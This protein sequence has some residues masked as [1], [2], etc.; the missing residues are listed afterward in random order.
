M[1]K[2]TPSILVTDISKSYVSLSARVRIRALENF[3]FSCFPGTVTLLVGANG[4]GKST[5]LRI[6]SGLISPSH[7]SIQLNT[8][9]NKKVKSRDIGYL[10]ENLNF[11]KGISSIRFLSYL[12]KLK[13]LK[14]PT[15]HAYDWLHTFGITN[16]WINLPMDLYSEGMKRR[17]GLAIA[18]MGNPEIIL[19]DEPLENLDESIRAKSLDLFNKL[20]HED[21]R[22]IVIATHNQNIFEQ[23]ADQILHL[24]AGKI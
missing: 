24:K 5:L 19:L 12:A 17:T 18:F 3:S 7:G 2:N 15:K 23:Y 4:S 16:R 11:H 21:K 8:N 13:N 9:S 1:K 22:T 14:K 20:A 10:P 6:L